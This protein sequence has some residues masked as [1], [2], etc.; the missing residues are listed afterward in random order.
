MKKY[1]EKLLSIDWFSRVGKIEVDS[2]NDFP[3]RFKSV[4]NNSEME[5][6]LASQKW[7]NKRIEEQAKVTL[8]LLENHKEKRKMWNIY[9]KEAK[10]FIDIYLFEKWK[11]FQKENGLSEKF[12]HS[13]VWNTLHYLVVSRFQEEIDGIPTFFLDIIEIYESGNVPCGWSGKNDR[14]FLFVY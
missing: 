1:E 8:Y 5:K 7:E 9:A 14:G 3:I 13:V 2:L 6:K 10:E 4:E 12:I 11:S